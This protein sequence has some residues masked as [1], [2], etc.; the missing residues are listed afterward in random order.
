MPTFF[1]YHYFRAMVAL[2]LLATAYVLWATRR[3]SRAMSQESR[4]G[5]ISLSRRVRLFA[6]GVVVASGAYAT[7]DNLVAP[8]LR[9]VIGPLLV[10]DA[11]TPLSFGLEIISSLLSVTLF[12]FCVGAFVGRRRPSH[13]ID[14]HW[15]S[16]PLSSTLGLVIYIQIADNLFG[17]T[18]MWFYWVP[19]TKLLQV[20][21]IPVLGARAYYTGATAKGKFCGAA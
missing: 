16:N 5:R 7:T 8:A 2:V 15:F 3:D 11:T 20:F 19:W 18:P 17:Y 14:G 9:R 13:P 4:D 1:A 6:A 10:H 21:C 12:A